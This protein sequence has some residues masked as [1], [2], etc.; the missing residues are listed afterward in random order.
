MIELRTARPDELASAEVLWTQTFGDHAETQRELYRLCGLEGPLTLWEHGRL[1]SM[2][3]LPEV[4][5]TMADGEKVPAGYIYALATRPESRGKRH[6]ARLLDYACEVAKERGYRCLITVP[7]QPSLFGFFSACNFEPAFWHRRVVVRSTSVSTAA[8]S[9]EEYGKLREQLLQNRCHVSYSDGLLAF[10]QML[11]PKPGSGLYRLDLP[12]GP[13]CAAI[14]LWP[15]YRVVKELLCHPEDEQEAMEGAAALC[16]GS[17]EI[18]I[19]ASAETGVPFGTVRWVDGQ[20]RP[21]EGY[22]GLAFD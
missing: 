21:L 9:P 3:A 22:L 16:G 8:V 17:T 12:H 5:L 13:A 20:S 10:Q 19:P 11:C 1:C 4:T 7:A 14:E 2:L 6:A 15:N 18:R